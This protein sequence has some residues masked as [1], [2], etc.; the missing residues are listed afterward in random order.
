[1]AEKTA[2]IDSNLIK[3]KVV[4]VS[5]KKVNFFNR[6]YNMYVVYV[7]YLRKRYPIHN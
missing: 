5:I 6:I 1:M 4:F 7:Q 2:E 3:I